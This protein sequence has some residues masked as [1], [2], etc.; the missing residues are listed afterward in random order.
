ME[1]DLQTDQSV[2][3][4]EMDK[5]SPTGSGPD[6]DSASL[7]SEDLQLDPKAQLAEIGQK[8]SS[9]VGSLFGSS[10]WYG[11][12][13]SSTPKNQEE[14]NKDSKNKEE[15]SSSGSTSFSSAFFNTIGISGD[16]KGGEK[17]SPEEGGGEG[18]N[19]ESTAGGLGYLTSA[20]S[21]IGISGLTSSKST[22]PLEEKEGVKEE[23]KAKE[24]EEED[25][26][27]SAFSK[28]GKA[29][30]SYS[31]VLHETV[32]KAPLLAD[33]NQQQ[34]NFI[35]EKGEKE[36]P[37]APWSGYQNENELKEKILA[38]SL[39]QRNF[40][41][42]PPSGVEFD[43]ENT[44][45]AMHALVLLKEDE[46]LEKVRYALV[47]KQ[48][49]E[50]DFWKNYFYRVGLIKQSFELSTMDIPRQDK[51]ADVAVKKEDDEVEVPAAEG[52][53]DDEFVS[54]SHQVSTKDLAEADEAMKKLGLDKEDAE[55]EAELEGELEYEV[56]EGD[57]DNPEWEHQIQEMLEAEDGK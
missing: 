27:Y 26:F 52:H 35:K 10:S 14:T 18:E 42:A 12:G 6:L 7:T 20:F 30:S 57:A 28:V 48:I 50:E 54:D 36:V 25:F 46:R 33:F 34:Q 2:N 21:K 3:G 37:S 13:S 17:E 49:K 44:A 8:A 53:Q 16:E 40:L 23:T 47:P 4:S 41:R 56:V 55:W 29:A 11:G 32:A 15:K 19:K 51:S 5:S 1:S 39:D 45:V 24:E 31:K 38:L 22:D 9:Y 43:M